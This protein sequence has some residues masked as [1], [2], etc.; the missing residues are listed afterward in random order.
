MKN[1]GGITLKLKDLLTEKPS[2]AAQQAKAM[3]LKSKGF[4]NWADSSG[5]VTHQTKKGKL[6]KTK[7]P[8]NPKKK[9]WTPADGEAS[10]PVSKKQQKREAD[11]KPKTVHDR[12]N[13]HFAGKN[14]KGGIQGFH[15]KY[16]KEMATMYSQG[17]A[18]NIE[19]AK[20]MRAKEEKKR[21]DQMKG[22]ER[23]KTFT[24]AGSQWEDGAFDDA[25][26]LTKSW[27]DDLLSSF[28]KE[29]G[30]IKND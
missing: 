13:G 12:G 5:K 26:G 19:K 22:Q 20:E 14:P 8:K 9:K 1:N 30:D 6:V 25:K 2:G 17:E 7:E 24:N 23:G 15:G 11:A 3:G 18:P 29:M 27:W 10:R 21:K 28:E 16:G 4:G